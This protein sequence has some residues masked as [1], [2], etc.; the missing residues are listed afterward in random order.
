MKI[1]TKFPLQVLAT[2]G[3]AGIVATYPLAA[4]SSRDVIIGVCLGAVISTVNVFAGFLGIEYSF[5]KS[6]ETFVRTVLGGM[7]IRMVFLLGMFLVLIMVFHVH[8]VALTISLL[9]FYAIHLFMEVLFL[10]KKAGGP[11]KDTEQ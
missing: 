8:A 2:V 4:F 6:H 1:D 5:N 9:G 7:G 3:I 10:Q 11:M